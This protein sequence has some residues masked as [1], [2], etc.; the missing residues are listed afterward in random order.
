MS[1]KLEQRV[2]ELEG[3][4]SHLERT[5]QQLD[6]VIRSQEQR[7]TGLEKR[8]TLLGGQFTSIAEWVAEQRDPGEE[9]PPHY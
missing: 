7:L 1:D 9:R 6:E 5:I 8:A 2:T 3:L 4:H